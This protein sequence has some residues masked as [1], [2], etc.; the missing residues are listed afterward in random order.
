M[1][2]ILKSGQEWTLPAQLK[3]LKMRQDEKGLLQSHLW[4][5]NDFAR[6]WNKIEKNSL[7]LQ[8]DIDA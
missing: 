7:C 3:Q 8:P 5:P 2:T 1:Y 4:C 6:S